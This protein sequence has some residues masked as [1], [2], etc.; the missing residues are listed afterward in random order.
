MWKITVQGPDGEPTI[1]DLK[2]GVNTVGRLPDSDIFIDDSAASRQHAEFVYDS[3]KDTLSIR[4]LNSSNG[5]YLNLKRIQDQVE[6]QPNDVVRIGRCTISFT[7]YN[8]GPVSTSEPVTRPIT[9]ELRVESLNRETGLMVQA[10]RKLNTITDIREALQ[11]V[12]RL[13]QQSMNADKSEVILAE[14]FHR[15]HELGFPESIAQNAIDQKNAV[16]I[17]DMNFFPRGDISQSARLYRVR[18]ALCVP[19][20]DADENVLGVL[21]LYKTQADARPFDQQDLQTAVAIGHLAAL[22]IQRAQLIDTIRKEQQLRNL[23]RR[24]LSPEEADLLFK[25]YLETG[26]LPELQEADV[27]VLFSDVADSTSMA[28]RLGARKFGDILARFYQDISEVTF[29]YSGLIK[30]LGDGVMAVFGLT[31]NTVS[32]E[33]RA[34]Q[35]GLEIVQRVAK[36][37]Q[38][39]PDD[40]VIV[41]VGINTGKAMAG[42]VGSED[43]VEYTVL[44]DMVNVASRLQN[45][46]RPNRVVAGP[47]TVA[48]IFGRY[49]TERIG[50]V[51]VRGREK[52]T[53]IYEVLRPRSDSLED[54]F[55]PPAEGIP[56]S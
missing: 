17:Q 42:Y 1:S 2:S 22:T 13:I 3:E 49:D 31:Q 41:G 47:A 53:Q 26:K 7:F 27:T 39:N 51:Q 9:R 30:F 15:L 10:A 5:T 44:G 14:E 6:I 20:T 33:E 8:T 28:E 55:P 46:A 18:S 12:S 35:A 32:P 21:Y 56:T 37:N 34:V 38:D 54:Q 48:A 50:E 43:R 4:D 45:Y 40:P 23:L 24:F 11:E 16:L 36:M 52:P 25:S 29:K 19:V